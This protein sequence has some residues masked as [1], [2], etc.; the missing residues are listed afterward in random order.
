MNQKDSLLSLDEAM[1]QKLMGDES[2][3]ADTLA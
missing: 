2:K 3:V 1:T